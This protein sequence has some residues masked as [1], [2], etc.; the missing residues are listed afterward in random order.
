MCDVAIPPTIVA[1]SELPSDRE[2]HYTFGGES[3]SAG[4]PR[5][6]RVAMAASAS[7]VAKNTRPP[8]KLPV[9]S[10][11]YPTTG[12]P[13]KP[14]SDAE[15]VDET[16]AARPPRCLPRKRV[17]SDQNGPRVPRSPTAAT[18][19]AMMPGNGEEK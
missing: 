11:M 5:S 10:W 9:R 15:C 18:V 4:A 19:R 13:T 7:S 14:P 16:D 2:Q 1:N 12:G 6:N 17:G 8:A 3:A